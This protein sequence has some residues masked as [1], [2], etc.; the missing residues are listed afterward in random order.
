[1]LLHTPLPILNK[2]IEHALA[3]FGF[4]ANHPN[5]KHYIKELGSQ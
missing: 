5:L 1:M 2:L 4:N 3:F